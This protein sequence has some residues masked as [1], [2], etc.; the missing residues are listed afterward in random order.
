VASRT[1]RTFRVPVEGDPDD[2]A[3]VTYL[4]A[5]GHLSIYGDKGMVHPRELQQRVRWEAD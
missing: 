5:L 2:E 3:W 1:V 4:A